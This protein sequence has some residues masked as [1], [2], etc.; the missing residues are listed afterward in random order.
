MNLSETLVQ[1]NSDYVF[2]C[3]PIRNNI[4][5]NSLFHRLVYSTPL[6]VLNGIYVILPIT[7]YSIDKFYNKYKCSFDTNIYKDVIENIGNIEKTLLT[8]A[9]ISTKTPQYR[10]YEQLKNG[11]IKLTA[12]HI[13]KLSSDITLKISGIWETEQEYGFTCKFIK[14]YS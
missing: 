5:D 1:H 7:Q 4:M 10:I 8:K 3:E 12:E 2:F 9:N 13:T 11:T 14:S 6:F